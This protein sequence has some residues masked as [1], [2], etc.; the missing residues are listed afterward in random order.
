MALDARADLIPGGLDVL[1]TH[2]P[3]LGHGDFIPT[4]EKQQTKYGNFGGEHVG[5]KFLNDAIELTKPKVVICGHIH[6]DRGRHEVGGVPVLNVAA[7]DA[8]YNLHPLPFVRLYELE[9]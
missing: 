4:S 2:G 1:M 7:V 3:P 9:A 5:D 6:E 8:A